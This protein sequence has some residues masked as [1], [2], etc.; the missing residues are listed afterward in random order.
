MNLHAIA[1]PLDL[2]GLRKSTILC[3][4]RILDLDPEATIWVNR[5]R[6]GN[7]RLQYK[8]NVM[9]AGGYKRYVITG[10]D[11]ARAKLRWREHNRALTDIPPSIYSYGPDRVIW[12][13][14]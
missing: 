1:L 5:T 10:W 4:E 11:I 3:A 7:R 12:E 14:P 6:S 13:V 9:Y 2:S 8:S